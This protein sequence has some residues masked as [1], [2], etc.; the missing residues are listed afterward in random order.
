MSSL[1]FGALLVIFLVAAA[2]TWT[3]DRVDTDF[4]NTQRRSKQFAHCSS[5]CPAAA[6]MGYWP[7]RL[8]S[9]GEYASGF[10]RQRKGKHP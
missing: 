2:A 7:S 4:F 3:T 9:R 6:S 5:F 8:I 1:G 10:G